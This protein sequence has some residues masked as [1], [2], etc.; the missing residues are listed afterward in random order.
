MHLQALNILVVE[1]DRFQ[2]T[3]VV[4][5]LRALGLQSII[6][7]ANGQEAL[8]ILRQPAS[9]KIDLIFSDLRMPGMDGMEFLRHLSEEAHNIEIVILS[10]MDKKLLSVVNKL[11]SLYQI[12]LLG[13]LEKP[14]TLQKLK[15]ILAKSGKAQ[16]V[17][18]PA[19][20]AKT[21]NFSVEEIL[22]GIQQKQFK[23]FLQPKVDLKTGKIVGAE[24]LARWLHPTHGVIAPYAFIP[25]LEQ[26]EQIDTLTFLILE[27]SAL[28][29]RALLEQNHVIHIA[30]N[31]S[32]VSLSQPHI[33]DKITD[34]VTA[35]DIDTKYIT[36]EIT[37]SAAM[38]DAPI[39]LENLAR[40]Y[41]NGFTLSIDDYGT[42]YSNLQQLTR[43][44]FGELKID[45]SF[46]QGVT[47][48]EATMIVVASN[49]DM[50][51][52]LNIKSVAEGVETEQDWEKLME[53]QCDIGQGYYIAKPMSVEEFFGYA[54]KYRS[55]GFNTS[56]ASVKHFIKTKTKQYNPFKMLVIDSDITSR[57]TL[58]NI[59]RD[60]GYQQVS[61]AN[62]A[63]SAFKLLATEQFDLIITELYTPNIN[64]LEFTKRIR[65]AKTLAKS[66]TR[67]IIMSSLI[68]AKAV[69]IAMTLNVN[70]F[71]TKPFIPGVID[72]KLQ[73]VLSEVFR[74]QAAIA[75]ET[76]NTAFQ[77]QS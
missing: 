68:Q 25:V 39:A 36:L 45:Q 57:N 47:N 66:S 5:M 31:L 42:G 76:V 62:D 46:V 15:D 26:A 48:N 9:Q 56:P 7:V 33:A 51:H 52:K 27:E 29:C 73:G 3:I 32:L 54:E 69:G 17:T 24:A 40:L 6:E 64:G 50:A 53:L 41:M 30:V 22:E 74:A 21:F 14:I 55:Q 1:D 49:I 16:A 20:T 23:P 37:E 13:A 28:A 65:T 61:T 2:R 12:Q 34:I 59:L 44:A 75:Y 19:H 18:T 60:S 35:C 10:A 8:D 4:E 58:V 43:I 77:E 67:I 38:T 70:G 11:S 71:I 63:E 72:K